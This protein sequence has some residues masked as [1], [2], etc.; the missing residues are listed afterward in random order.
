MPPAWEELYGQGCGAERLSAA[1]RTHLQ[2][3]TGRAGQWL[4]DRLADPA[5]PVP[6]ASLAEVAPLRTVWAQHYELR[7]G[8]VGY[9]TLEW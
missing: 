9:T 5:S 7:E 4:L 2:A 6:L 8:Q 1:E 3:E